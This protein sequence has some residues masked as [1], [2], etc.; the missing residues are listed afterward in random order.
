[1]Q[2]RQP[3]FVAHV[4]VQS[5]AFLVTQIGFHELSLSK[6]SDPQGRQ[7]DGLDIS[8][9]R[10]APQFQRFFI[11]VSRRLEIILQIEYIAQVIQCQRDPTLIADLANGCQA[12]FQQ[13]L[14]SL[15]ISS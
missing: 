7:C 15:I 9:I 4:P 11:M 6:Q 5:H 14:G 13:F 3:N 10:F 2:Q 12:L 1:M 8:I